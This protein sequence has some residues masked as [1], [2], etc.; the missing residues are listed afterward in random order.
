MGDVVFILTKTSYY[1]AR[2]DD[3]LDKITDYEQ[4]LLEDIVKI[5]FGIPEQT[6]S[7]FNKSFHCFRLLYKVDGEEGF[8]HMM[9]STNMKFFNNLVSVMTTEEEKV[10]SLKAIADTVGVTMEVSGLAPNMWFGKL[11][12]RRSK[13]SK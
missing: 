13:S 4:V 8:H 12:K 3:D 7:L 9:R 2:Y 6:F 5:E 10:E 1:F 11:E